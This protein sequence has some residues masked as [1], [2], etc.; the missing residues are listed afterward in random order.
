M[1]I[2]R[3]VLDSD[4]FIRSKREHYGF[5]I[6]PGFWD[7]L[8]CFFNRGHL[9]SIVPV[10]NELLKGPADDLAEWVKE[11][12]PEGF[13]VPADEPEV[14]EAFREVMAWMESQPQY[15]EAAKE[16][17]ASGAD[18]W[19]IAYA[20]VKRCILVT[21]EQPAP[22]SQKSVKIPDAADVLG[23]KCCPVHEMLTY[24]R[25]E[26]VLMPPVELA[27]EQAEDHL[28]ATSESDDE[29]E[30]ASELLDPDDEPLF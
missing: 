17:F 21:Y 10:R 11:R 26:L 2:A 8:D 27:L 29:A 15:T 9:C 4:T 3:F 30:L 22:T 12:A 25:T 14:V 16:R 19:L 28:V 18:P 20:A 13:F 1:S 7:A 24:L 23:V 6:C 5:A